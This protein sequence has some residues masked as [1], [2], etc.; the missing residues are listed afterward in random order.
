MSTSCL[1]TLQVSWINH[2]TTSNGDILYQTSS[3]LKNYNLDS[4]NNYIV[5]KIH[6]TTTNFRNTALITT[7]NNT[8]LPKDSTSQSHDHNRSLSDHFLDATKFTKNIDEYTPKTDRIQNKNRS[9]PCSALSQIQPSYHCNVTLTTPPDS[10]ILTGQKHHRGF[11]STMLDTASLAHRRL[12]SLGFSHTIDR[13]NNNS[14]PNSATTV[15]P[16]HRHKRENSA[17]LDL[18]SVAANATKELSAGGYPLHSQHHKESNSYGEQ[19]PP[20]SVIYPSSTS[21]P[22]FPYPHNF[23]YYP[24]NPYSTFYT[25]P[26]QDA[27]SSP[28]HHVQ[29]HSFSSISSDLRLDT[30]EILFGNSSSLNEPH[31]RSISSCSLSMLF[32]PSMNIN[33]PPPPPEP[34]QNTTSKRLRR[35]CTIPHCPNRVV[36]GGLCISHGAKRKTCQFVG[37]TKHVKK[38]GMCS[39]HGPARKKCEIEGCEKVSVQGGRCIGHGA[40]KK[41]CI[42][43]GCGKQGIIAGMCKKH[44]DICGKLNLNTTKVTNPH[45]TFSTHR[46][47]PVGIETNI[48]NPVEVSHNRSQHHNTHSGSQPNPSSHV[49]TTSLDNSTKIVNTHR[50]GLS[51]FQEMS[52]VNTIL[53]GVATVEESSGEMKELLYK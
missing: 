14:N 48:R 32:P 45:G 5:N 12:D 39:T 38:A 24:P 44:H 28:S 33:T 3:P 11:S 27:Y 10:E 41:M 36:Q 2:H 37:C 20:A 18:L 8:D 47:I 51:I 23:H 31:H 21:N 35:K 6:K 7:N 9:H 40:R 30:D 52:T 16:T 4:N 17:G 53:K 19:T 25:H 29:H 1:P 43:E 13:C 34:I 50:R 49:S 42:V 46:D 22:S 15:S 26:R